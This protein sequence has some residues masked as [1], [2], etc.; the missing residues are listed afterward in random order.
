M[1]ELTESST[2]EVGVVE[3]LWPWVEEGPVAK[4]PDAGSLAPA[5]ASPLPRENRLD[6]RA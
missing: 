2:L 4:C 1:L 6:P 3:L 5:C